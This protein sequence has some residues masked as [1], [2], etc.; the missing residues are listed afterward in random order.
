M[1]DDAHEARGA[2]SSVDV[3]P[4]YR[5]Y[6]RHA[7]G[8]AWA[9][10]KDEEEARDAV[11]ESF[12][13]V[14]RYQNRFEARSSQY[15]WLYRIVTNVCLDKL[16]KRRSK[17]EVG[18]DANLEKQQAGPAT[19]AFQPAAAYDAEELR[20]TLAAGIEQ[21]SEEHRRVIVMR[22]LEGLTYDQM[23][24]DC[25]CPRGTIMSRLFHARRKLRAILGDSLSSKILTAQG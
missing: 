20:K 11:Q 3:E 5:K 25:A 10:L 19:A 15:S 1:Q 17:R 6:H 8:L 2:L 24:K 9:M 21:L 16:R 18:L 22:E 23:A 4:L 13:K 14:L 12:V 7:Y